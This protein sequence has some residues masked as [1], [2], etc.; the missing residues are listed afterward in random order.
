MMKVV[1]S[2]QEPEPPSR[3]IHPKIDRQPSIEKYRRKS[4][5]KQK[6]NEKVQE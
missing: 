2:Y 4:K 6:K 1:G 5:E 3:A